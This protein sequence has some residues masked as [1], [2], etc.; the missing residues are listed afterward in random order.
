MA[1]NEEAP[2]EGRMK[3]LWCLSSLAASLGEDCRERGSAPDLQLRS[4]N[5]VPY[6][7][8]SWDPIPCLM[9]TGMPGGSYTEEAV[10]TECLGQW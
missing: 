2:A 1:N 5:W 6:C 8:H 4:P 7:H 9:G 3:P 10:G